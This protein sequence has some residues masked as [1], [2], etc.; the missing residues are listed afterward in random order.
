LKWFLPEFWFE[1]VDV[2]GLATAWPQDLDLDFAPTPVRALAARGLWLEQERI[3][4][5]P[6]MA[7]ALEAVLAAETPG[8]LLSH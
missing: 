3:V 4:F 1:L 5:D 6:R 7:D 2:C 8:Q